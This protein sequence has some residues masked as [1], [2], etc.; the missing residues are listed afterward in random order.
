MTRMHKEYEVNIKLVQK[1][2][3]QLKMKFELVI[4]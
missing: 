2:G 4:P 3:L 1:Q